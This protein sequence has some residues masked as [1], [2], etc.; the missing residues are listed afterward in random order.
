MVCTNSSYFIIIAYPI[1]NCI[2]YFIIIRCY[3]V[4]VNIFY[5]LTPIWI[6][7]FAFLGRKNPCFG[8]VYIHSQRN[9]QRLESQMLPSC[10]VQRKE[11]AIGDY[12]LG[13]N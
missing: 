4:Y 5:S 6:S 13:L 1:I 3:V 12:S 8:K 11:N 7:G 10:I 9:H 2:H